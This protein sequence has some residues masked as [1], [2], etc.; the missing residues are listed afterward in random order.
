MHFQFFQFIKSGHNA[1]HLDRLR[2][3]VIAWLALTIVCDLLL[4]LSIVIP[5]S[6]HLLRYFHDVAFDLFNTPPL[7]QLLELKASTVYRRTKEIID[8]VVLRTVENGSITMLFS[9]PYIVLYVKYPTTFLG[10]AA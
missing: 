5:V 2:V 10:V 7:T 8:V 3:V 4:T 1:E 6:L 9:I